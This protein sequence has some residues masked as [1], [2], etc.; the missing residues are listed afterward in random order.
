[1][2]NPPNSQTLQ[3]AGLSTQPHPKNYQNFLPTKKFDGGEYALNYSMKNTQDRND[4]NNKLSK[5]TS[6]PNY[7]NFDNFEI[8]PVELELTFKLLESITNI[9]SIKLDQVT[10]PLLAGQDYSDMYLSIDKVI[11]GYKYRNSYYQ[12]NIKAKNPNIYVPAD[13]VVMK[14]VNK[15]CV[16]NNTMDNINVLTFRFR[17]SYFDEIVFPKAVIKCKTIPLTNPIQLTHTDHGLVNGD[18][19][20]VENTQLCGTYTVT[21][22]DPNTFTIPYNGI[23]LTTPLNPIVKI[24]KFR[25]LIRII[26]EQFN[27]Y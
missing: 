24:P 1:M 10:L 17:N 11:F 25:I 27:G 13:K 26:F 9:E 18:T 16:F 21:V 4:I 14:A 3:R 8:P 22:I 20:I 6:T 23:L 2:Y 5:L 19:I 12:F 7:F 15:S